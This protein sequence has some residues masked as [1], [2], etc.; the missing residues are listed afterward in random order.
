M[1]AFVERLNT[2]LKGS[3]LV[4]IRSPMQYQ[5]EQNKAFLLSTANIKKALQRLLPD[6]KD[7][8]PFEEWYKA[9]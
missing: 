5:I 4:V 2:A 7:G 6:G 1:S 9:I 8:K 3:N